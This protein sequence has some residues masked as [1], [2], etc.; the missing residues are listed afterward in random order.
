MVFSI[1]ARTTKHSGRKHTVEFAANRT[2][3]PD[4]GSGVLV[5]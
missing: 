1:N 5:E 3:V 4:D 2:G